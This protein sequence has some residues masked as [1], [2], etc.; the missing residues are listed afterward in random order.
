MLWERTAGACKLA[1]VERTEP[2]I[3]VDRVT[4]TFPVVSSAW[5]WLRTMGRVPR[6]TIVSDV[7]FTVARGETFG[8]L[9]PNGAGKT[10]V[11]KLL[12][13][14]AIPDAG[15]VE[16]CG[17][18]TDRDA[19]AARRRIAYCGG[20][21]RSFYFRLTVGDNLRFFG[22]LAGLDGA[23]LRRRIDEALEIVDLRDVERDVY[24]SL[25]TGM[26]QRLA[27]ARALLARPDIVLFDEFTRA[28]DPIH[29]AALRSLVRDRLVTELGKTVV[30]AT[31]L[32]D[33]AWSLCDRV[34]LL[35]EGRVVALDVPS[36]LGEGTPEAIFTA[37]LRP[38]DA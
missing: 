33:E 26:R 35:D 16:V 21:E 32:L 5:T 9:G 7:S 17:I 14:L 3:V 34:A 10:T 15:R 12:A 6:K 20:G 22:T 38:S 18:A 1:V 31:N 8:L 24:G 2:A 13:T 29:A 25:S 19:A 36:R 37:L 4:K 28:V 11:L 23:L 30:V 27:V